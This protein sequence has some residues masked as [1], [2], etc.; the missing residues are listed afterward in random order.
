MD[1]SFSF[2]LAG[3]A[4][5]LG[6]SAVIMHLVR[7]RWPVPALTVL[8]IFI[9][10]AVLI[11]LVALGFQL[12]FWSYAAAFGP[13]LVFFLFVFSAIYRSLSVRVMSDLLRKEGN[14]AAYGAV[15]GEYIVGESFPNRIKVLHDLG[16]S[17]PQGEGLRATRWGILFG[18]A[19]TGLQRLFG[20]RGSG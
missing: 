18:R 16:L 3:V 7:P 4:V 15:L 2:G 9:F 11:I 12:N 20:I 10:T 1:F 13:A 8:W 17:E 19:V 6:A 14:R 5:A